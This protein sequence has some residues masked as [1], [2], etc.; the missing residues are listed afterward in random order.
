VVPL[1]LLI[2]MGG[3]VVLHRAR[4]E[5]GAPAL[6]SDVELRRENARVDL[7]VKSSRSAS[8]R[9]GGNGW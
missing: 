5:V 8:G 6:D 9:V 3:V 4:G 2:R 1:A 7:W